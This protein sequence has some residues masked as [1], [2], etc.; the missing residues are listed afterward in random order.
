LE[1]GIKKTSPGIKKIAPAL[2]M[3]QD[4][5]LKGDLVLFYLPFPLFFLLSF[6]LILPKIKGGP[7]PLPPRSTSE[8]CPPSD[9]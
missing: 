5:E 9:K 6:L 2:V 4:L 3:V 8:P 1:E 7:G